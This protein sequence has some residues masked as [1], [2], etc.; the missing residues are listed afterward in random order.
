MCPWSSWLGEEQAHSS[1]IAGCLA[2]TS[3][4]KARM[5]VRSAGQPA[6]QTAKTSWITR[7][8]LQVE[9]V[10]VT[11]D[12][13]IFSVHHADGYPRVS[14]RPRRRVGSALELVVPKVPG[15][16]AQ[17]WTKQERSVAGD[18]VSIPGYPGTFVCAYGLLDWLCGRGTTTTCTGSTSRSTSRMALSRYQYG[19]QVYVQANYEVLR[20]QHTQK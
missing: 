16:R 3:S 1:L 15:V 7:L 8:F 12:L 4:R 20:F 19:I 17:A 13:R 18:A 11:L 2:P 9:M 10:S 5:P 14:W 6:V